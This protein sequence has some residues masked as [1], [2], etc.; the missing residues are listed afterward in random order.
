MILSAPRFSTVSITPNPTNVKE[1]LVISVAVED[2]LFS[3]EYKYARTKS[4]AEIYA[5]EIGGL[6]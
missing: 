4:G 3:T 5:G 6:I 1:K 2:V